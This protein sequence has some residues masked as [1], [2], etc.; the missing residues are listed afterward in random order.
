MTDE[1]VAG[2]L[3][4]ASDNTLW[5]T[6]DY[7]TATARMELAAVELKQVLDRGGMTMQIGNSEHVLI[8]G[9]QT[10]GSMLGISPYV[11]W[12]RPLIEGGFEARA[13]A[14]TVDGRVVGAAEAMC[15]RDERNWKNRDDYA[16]RSMAQTR[17]M[18]KALRGPLGFVITLAGRNP[19]PAEEMPPEGSEGPQTERD[20]W[21]AWVADITDDEAAV[22]RHARQPG[23][24]AAGH[25]HTR[26]PRRR[27]RR[28][29]RARP[30]LRRPDTG[31]RG[32]YG[33]AAGAGR[34]GGRRTPRSGPRRAGRIVADAAANP[35]H[36]TRD[37]GRRQIPQSSFQGPVS[38]H[39]PDH[40]GRR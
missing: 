40:D 7:A 24:A 18:S 17:A 16:L 2:E 37:L 32:A 39:W 6:D 13:E 25:R 3:V 19:T 34:R 30:V 10:L 15:T 29:A 35:D 12:S 36:Q 14:R 38:V 31:R 9:W 27:P 28:Y 8:D 20:W 23:R 1:T 4:P 11:V 26:P 22:E 33:Q 5:H 21:P